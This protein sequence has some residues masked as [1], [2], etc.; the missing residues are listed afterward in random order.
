MT[1]PG[2]G[3]ITALAYRATVDDPGRFASSKA[4]G[5]HLGMTP[6]VYQSGETERSG[7][8]SKAGDRMLRHLLYEAASALLAR[9]SK[10]SKLRA[11]GAAIARRRGAKRARV[12]IARKLGV[13][14][15]KIW[16]TGGRFETGMEVARLTA[17]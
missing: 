2:V 6:R 8:I 3:P 14:L 7:G 12:A 4:V 10:P 5:A 15:H 13:I 1:V 9:S 11:W 17:A 16:I